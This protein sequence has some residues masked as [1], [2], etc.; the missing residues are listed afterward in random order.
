METSLTSNKNVHQR[1]SGAGVAKIKSFTE[2]FDDYLI[3]RV[4]RFDLLTLSKQY[5]Q[6]STRSDNP[7]SKS[8]IMHGTIRTLNIKLSEQKSY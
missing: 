6:R 4:D 8:H 2:G 7:N 3:D 5:D 1:S